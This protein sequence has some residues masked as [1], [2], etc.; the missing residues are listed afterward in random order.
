MPRMKSVTYD[1]LIPE[2]ETFR[3]VV[4]DIVSPTLIAIDGNTND[5]TAELKRVRRTNELILGQ[6]VDEPSD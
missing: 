2:P 3:D 1:F 4:E 6:E 5:V